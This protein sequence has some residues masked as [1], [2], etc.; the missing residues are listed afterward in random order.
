MPG[1]WIGED[2]RGGLRR[3]SGGGWRVLLKPATQ[4]LLMLVAALHEPLAGEP[5]LVWRAAER[6]GIGAG[7]LA[8]AADS[9][10]LTIGERVVFRHPLVRSAVYQ[11][12]P[13]PD[14]RAAHRALA[15]ATDPR[16]DP[17]RRAWH[18]ARR[19]R[20][21]PMRTLRRSWS[22]RRAAPRRAM[23]GWPRRAAF[24]GQPPQPR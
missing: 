23:R 13:A 22:G 2:C 8:P 20:R 17:D 11:A 7:A 10:L 12:A 18:S 21:G 15:G 4:Q 5:G 24:L 19:P 9:G 3:V 14:R 1:S 6:L 16:A